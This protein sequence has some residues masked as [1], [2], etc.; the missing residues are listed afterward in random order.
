[1]LI[2]PPVVSLVEAEKLSAPIGS[3]VTVVPPMVSAGRRRRPVM[4][5]VRRDPV[6]AVTSP[7]AGGRK[8]GG[9]PV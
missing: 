8:I 4:L 5:M 9:R 3:S 7:P 1:M 6:G 2:V